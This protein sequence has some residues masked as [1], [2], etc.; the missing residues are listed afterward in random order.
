MHVSPLYLEYALQAISKSA[1]HVFNLAYS[2]IENFHKNAKFLLNYNKFLVLQNSDPIIQS[3]NNINKKKRVKSIATYDFPTLYTKLLHDEIKSK[4][5]SILD[6]AFK[7]GDKTFISIS[8]IS[9]Q[10]ST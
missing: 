8:Y 7:G 3:L 5:S 6:V 10:Q 9:T 1:S 4:L 2:Q